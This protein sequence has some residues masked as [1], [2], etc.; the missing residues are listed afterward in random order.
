MASD[1]EGAV[2]LERAAQRRRVDELA[3]A[4]AVPVGEPDVADV[5]EQPPAGAVRPADADLDAPAPRK[6]RLAALHWDDDEQKTYALLSLRCEVCAFGGSDKHVSEIYGP[7]RFTSR[8]TEFSLTPGCAMDLRSGWNFTKQADR[9]RARAELKANR[10]WLLIGSPPCGPF[11][12]MH[13]LFD[14]TPNREMNY[15]EGI[16]H[17]T[18]LLEL[19]ADQAAAGRFFLHE[20][21]RNNSSWTTDPVKE[22]QQIPGAFVIESD[23]CCFGLVGS[24]EHG[25]ALI[26]KPTRWIS[27]LARL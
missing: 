20:Q 11:S 6:R 25:E 12:T 19:Y 24:D 8:A 15:M 9:D 27:N 13:N 5:A 4:P 16:Q 10:P 23:Q 26:Q 22:M 14:W 1:T 18:F 21:P 17:L 3:V 2:E 7:G